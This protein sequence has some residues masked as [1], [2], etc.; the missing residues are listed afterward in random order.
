MLRLHRVT[1]QARVQGRLPAA[2]VDAGVVHAWRDTLNWLVKVQDAPRGEHRRL[3]L[4]QRRE[5]AR[6]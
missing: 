6:Q 4:K 2:T 1:R 5:T 3:P